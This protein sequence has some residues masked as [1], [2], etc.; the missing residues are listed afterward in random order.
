MTS[1]IY[2]KI[3][4]P[5]LPI[6][7]LV[8]DWIHLIFFE[9]HLVIVMPFLSFK[10]ITHVY[11]LKISITHNKKQIPLLNLLIDCVSVRSASQILS[12]KGVLFAF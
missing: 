5:C 2:Y 9:K 3:H 7:Y 11:L 6:P 4:Y 8:C 12:I 10:E 1:L